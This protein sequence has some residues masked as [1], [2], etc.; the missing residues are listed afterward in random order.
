MEK[1]VSV[2]EKEKGK[3][4]L[5][6]LITLAVLSLA[7]FLCLYQHGSWL[8]VFEQLG[9]WLINPEIHYTSMQVSGVAN[10]LF[11]TIEIVDQRGR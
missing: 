3:Q 5:F 9:T 8:V 7:L 6:P 11:A 10:A 4:L 1:T 2:D